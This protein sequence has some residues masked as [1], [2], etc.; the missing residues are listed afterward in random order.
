MTHILWH[1]ACIELSKLM[2]IMSAEVFIPKWNARIFFVNPQ[3]NIFVIFG[4]SKQKI[5][6]CEQFKKL[7]EFSEMVFFCSSLQEFSAILKPFIDCYQ[8]CQQSP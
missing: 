7:F 2:G 4:S 3:Q 6:D 1:D 8:T 5:Q